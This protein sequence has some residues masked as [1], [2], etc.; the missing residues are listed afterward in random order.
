MTSDGSTSRRGRAFTRNGQELEI[1]R[2]TD[3]DP[4]RV[5]GRRALHGSPETD[6][7]LP[8]VF[9]ADYGWQ[10]TPDGAFV[11]DEPNAASTWFPSNDHPQRQGDLHVQGLR[12]E[13]PRVANGDLFRP[14][15]R[16]A[17]HYIWN[18]T[19][20]MATYLATI[21]IGNW[22]SERNDRRA[23]S[24]RPWGSTRPSHR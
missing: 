7:R 1:T 19:S 18:E 24:A 10:Y 6:Q 22:T 13:R 4:T 23:A 12:S 9:G 5:L 11:G 14:A 21:D 16:P 15:P 2:R 3:L 8:I 17:R 20:P